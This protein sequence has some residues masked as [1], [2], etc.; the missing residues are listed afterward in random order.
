MCATSDEKKQAGVK[1]GQAAGGDGVRVRVEAVG[2]STIRSLRTATQVRAIS[3]PKSRWQRRRRQHRDDHG[4][5][6]TP[7]PLSGPLRQCTFDH[8]GLYLF[9]LASGMSTYS[10][11]LLN[12]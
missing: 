7:Q 1:V 5:L 9:V 11:S 3:P 2:S 10:R 6:E 12:F 4:P 8:E